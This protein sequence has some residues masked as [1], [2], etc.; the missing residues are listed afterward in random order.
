MNSLELLA[1]ICPPDESLDLTTKARMR[2]SLFGDS[3]RSGLAP[4]ESN[5]PI[6]GHGS[7]R[8]PHNGKS[9]SPAF[10][11]GMGIAAAIAIVVGL[12]A[13]THRPG[14]HDLPVPPAVSNPPSLTLPDSSPSSP[15]AVPTALPPLVIANNTTVTKMRYPDDGT[16]LV[17]DVDARLAVPL[18]DGRVLI[19]PADGLPMIWTPG[20][21]QPTE[22]FSDTASWA[23]PVRL[24][25]A[26]TIDGTA[27]MLY[28]VD[29]ACPT[30]PICSPTLFLVPIDAP[31][32][33]KV[34]TTPVAIGENTRFTLSDT[35][36]VAGAPDTTDV[37]SFVGQFDGQNITDDTPTVPPPT[38]RH[39]LLA[40]DRSGS[41]FAWLDGPAVI[42]QLIATGA[43]QQIP[44]PIDIAEGAVVGLDVVATT[45]DGTHGA[46]VLSTSSGAIFI[47]DLADRSAKRLDSSN[48]FALF[49]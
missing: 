32:E 12:V 4:I 27:W 7:H 20:I 10:R 28:S 16:S 35:G 34:V 38:G 9:H 45:D 5:G 37:A 1:H 11:L 33:S 8:V 2:A 17:A 49:G 22:L 36:I 42:V 31:A 43:Q 15:P 14:A 26:A 3:D 39:S 6:T 41:V 47:I 13:I 23:G 18:E 19:Q 44:L 46:I 48:G 25:D 21:A 24:Q 29:P 40:V 30:E